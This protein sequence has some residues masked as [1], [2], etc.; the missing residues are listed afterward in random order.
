MNRLMRYILI[1]EYEVSEAILKENCVAPFGTELHDDAWENL[2]RY[3]DAGV[4]K[5]VVKFDVSMG[6]PSAVADYLNAN[7]PTVYETVEDLNAVIDVDP[8]E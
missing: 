3:D 5:A 1:P 8:I 7:N 4:M 2:R 6:T